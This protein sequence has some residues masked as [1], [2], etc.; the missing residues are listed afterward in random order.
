MK[1][2]ATLSLMLA[3]A[4]SSGCSDNTTTKGPPEA[5]MELLAPGSVVCPDD[6]ANRKPHPE[7]LYR[8]CRDLACAPHEAIYV[9]DH[10]RDIEAGPDGN[11]Y[12]LLEHSAGSQIV[13]IVPA[14]EPL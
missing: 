4:L 14:G 7:T 6:I 3:A 5:A 8:N 2:F 9:G 13:R 12:L 1:R 10:L 11:L